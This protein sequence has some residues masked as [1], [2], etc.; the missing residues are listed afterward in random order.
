MLEILT[1]GCNPKQQFGLCTAL[2]GG[3][4]TV[5]PTYGPARPQELCTH[6]QCLVALHGWC[7]GS[8]CSIPRCSTVRTQRGPALLVAMGPGCVGPPHPPRDPSVHPQPGSKVGTT[9]SSP[10]R[11]ST[12]PRQALPRSAPTKQPRGLRPQPGNPAQPQGGRE[13]NTPR[14]PPQRPPFCASI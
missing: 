9:H 2:P 13:E 10:G 1:Q 7:T 14:V 6:S 4:S 3:S 12:T 5:C 8:G 11:Q